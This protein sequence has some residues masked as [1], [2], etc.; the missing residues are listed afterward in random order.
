MTANSSAVSRRSVLA[1]IASASAL[2]LWAQSM[3]ANP[4]VV[5]VG[6]GSAGLSAARALIGMG[7]T[8]VIVEGANRIGG[9]AYTES[10]TFGIPFD[11]GCSWVTG[12]RNL[13]YIRMARKWGFELL[14]H[15]GAGEALFVGDRRANAAEKRKSDRAW[16]SID[17]ALE[18][19]GSQGRDV[20]G[21]SV[22]PKGLDFSGTAQTW[23]G[24]M[25]WGVD[26]QDLST[27]DVSEYGSI[28]HYSLVKEGYG[29][30]VSRMGS[31]LPVHLKTPATRID[32]SGNG[33]SV[34]TP[35][36]TIRAKAC[37]VTVS[38]GVLNA[39]SIKF[40]P[41]LPDWKRQAIANLPMGLLAKIGLQFDG[42]RFG[43][44]P[45]DWLTYRVPDEMPAEAC[46]FLTWPFDSNIMVGFVG[47]AFGWEISG[48]GQR[49][50]INFALDEL[51]KVLGS[52][53]R[54]H[55]VKGQ[56]TGWAQNPMT[57]GAYTAAR[58]GH[59]SARAALAKP[60]GDRV[61]FAG[62]AVA[63][64]YHQLCAGAY[65]SGQS[66]ARQVAKTL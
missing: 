25:D 14:D 40:T 13:P 15:S 9:R 21:S 38:T 5:I 1:G 37:I 35:A 46:Y 32:W 16:S 53:V 34:H 31:G 55:F 39:G 54:K 27:K 49:A 60:V 19:A 26:L 56:L 30:L 45:N 52:N 41:K 6:A 57:F 10:H 47:G 66:V 50:A 22:V 36:G 20:A 33:V 42:N 8:V 43:L 65:M 17:A 11:H 4:D 28:G 3:P 51:V 12:P 48:A 64:P 24:P 18:R 44:T 62:E 23:I 58:P 59:H 61:F 2:P 7:K 63:T 29:T